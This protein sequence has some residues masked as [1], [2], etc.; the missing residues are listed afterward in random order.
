[1]FEGLPVTQE[2]FLKDINSKIEQNPEVMLKKM[3]NSRKDT[4]TKIK[5][6]SVSLAF[7]KKT[8]KTLDQLREWYHLRTYAKD[9]ISKAIAKT[10]PVLLEMCRRKGIDYAQMQYLTGSEVENLFDISKENLIE[11]VN[12]RKEGWAA[13][14]TK[15][16]VYYF[17]SDDIKKVEEKEEID[18]NAVEIKGQTAS[19][20][21]VRGVVRFVK[22]ATELGKVKK[23]D[24]LVTSMTT[25]DFTPILD[26]ISGL[27]TDEGGLTCHAAIVSREL[28]IPCI[29]G[30]KIATKVLKD[31]DKIELDAT[32]GIIRKLQTLRV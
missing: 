20:G 26:K 27:I 10:M 28:G 16:D 30:T 12:K 6:I 9:C 25:T 14:A 31:E 32:K 15:E 17:T 4:E 5:M 18:N 1:M 19:R 29:I 7:S 22:D 13:V 21:F 23:G 2:D 11:R 24:I 8:L 3:E